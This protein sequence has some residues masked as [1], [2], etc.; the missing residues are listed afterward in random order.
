MQLLDRLEPDKGKQ[1][2]LLTEHLTGQ[3]TLP[4]TEQE[5]HKLHK[6]KAEKEIERHEAA[7]EAAANM[8]AEEQM[9]AHEAAMVAHLAQ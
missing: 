2:R 9:E 3:R 1:A 5:L 8:A 7:V 6:R 4:S